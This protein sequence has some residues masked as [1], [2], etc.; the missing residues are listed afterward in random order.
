M[1]ESAKRA[2]RL[3]TQMFFTPP[4]NRIQFIIII[5]VG[6]LF[7]WMPQKPPIDWNLNTNGFW[8]NLPHTYQL[9]PNFVYP[10]WGLF[11]LVPYFLMSASGARILSVLI[12]GWLVQNR[13]WPMYYFFAIVL[14]PYFMVTMAKS[15]M[16]ILVIVLPI[17][18]WE[19]SKGKKFEVIARGISI[20]LLLL[21]P[22][23]TVFILAYFLWSFRNHLKRFLLICSIPTLIIIPVSLVGSPPLIVQWFGNISHPSSQN[24]YYWS[25]NNI[26]LT[27]RFGYWI[28]LAVL[29]GSIILFYILYRLN[30]IEWKK[31]Q[32]YSAL[33]LLSMYS[34]PYTSQQSFSS[35]LAFIPSWPG[36]LFQWVVVGLGFVNHG[37]NNNIALLTFSVSLLSILLFSILQTRHEKKL[38]VTK[39]S[40]GTHKSE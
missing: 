19:Y 16:D 33:L 24:Q 27:A 6:L 14:S 34:L 20:S 40:P 35:G 11:L 22:Q 38:G 18:I 13:K 36:F 23:C 30:W 8:S 3:F 5:I 37:H 9:N 1:Y 29:A 31:T 2:G 28:S 4:E 21:K 26:S 17:L 10:P 12:I 39:S 25:I 15:N 7:I 32:I